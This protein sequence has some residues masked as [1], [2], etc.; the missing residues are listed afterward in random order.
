MSADRFH[1]MRLL[2]EPPQCG[3]ALRDMFPR[4]ARRA[5]LSARTTIEL[6]CEQVGAA[7]DRAVVAWDTRRL[8][9]GHIEDEDVLSYDLLDIHDALE[10]L[11]GLGLIKR[12]FPGRPSV[13]SFVP[14]IDDFDL[15]APA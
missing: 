13:I 9:A 2:G 8:Q 11:D 4:I 1:Q 10:C 15:A 7:G 12:P 3:A 6:L 14:G 5:I